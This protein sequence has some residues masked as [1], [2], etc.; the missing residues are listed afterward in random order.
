M[1]WKQKVEVT[2]NVFENTYF[3]NILLS[4]EVDVE[5]DESNEASFETERVSAFGLN[6]GLETLSHR[7]MIMEG[8]KVNDDPFHVRFSWIQIKM[9][10]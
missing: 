7:K 3:K 4:N 8:N 1:N 9:R 10:E 6:V 2:Q 5:M